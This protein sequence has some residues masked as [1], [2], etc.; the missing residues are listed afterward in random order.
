[1]YTQYVVEGLRT[2]IAD[3]NE[4]GVI[5]VDELHEFAG[6]K[7]REVA[8]AMQPKIYAAEEGYNIIIA[9]A[10]IGDSKL[11]YRKEVER[12]AKD[13]NG[14][15][16]D[17][18]LTALDTKQQQL[19]IS[20]SEAERIRQEVLSPYQEFA[21]K[22]QKYQKALQKSC[23]R[24]AQVTQQAWKD[25]QY[26]QQTLGLT[27][28]NIQ[29]LMDSVTVAVDYTHPVSAIQLQPEL[30]AKRNPPALRAKLQSKSRLSPRCISSR[31][32]TQTIVALGISGLVFAM[33]N[34]KLDQP[35]VLTQEPRS[36]QVNSIELAKIAEESA[37]QG[38]KKYDQKNFQ[39]AIED[40]TKA[41]Q[42]KS[43]DAIL[44]Q[45]R[46]QARRDLGK[47]EEALA[48]YTQAIQLK[49]ELALT[50]WKRGELYRELGKSKNAIEDYT[51]SL[52]FKPTEPWLVYHK[53]GM[54]KRSLNDKNGAIEDYKKAIQSKSDFAEVYSNRG[55]IYRELGNLNSA[56]ADFKKAADFYKQQGK[57]QESQESLK[58][59]QQLQQLQQLQQV[60]EES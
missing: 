46:G 25:L 44:Y 20:N 29:P 60:R 55:M 12:L 59:V 18:V 24:N 43:D 23:D 19:G 11:A 32:L 14:Q 22:F 33:P 34:L 35:I 4:D 17:I 39:G 2:G 40:Y 5:S 36:P 45:S 42:F 30:N 3:R 1:V 49:P 47:K 58:Q 10:P 6:E 50:Y 51:K 52:E 54:V 41:L 37:R 7:V 56:I 21:K 27:D 57:T 26:L 31:V 53:R 38:Q 9:K 13:R 48:D 16:S 28:K 8:P 15:L